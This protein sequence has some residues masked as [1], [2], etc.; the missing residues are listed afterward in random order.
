MLFT[1]FVMIIIF[2]G[3][4]Y[5]MVTFSAK[6]FTREDDENLKLIQREIDHQKEL[7]KIQNQKIEVLKANQDALEKK[8]D[9][10]FNPQKIE[11]LTTEEIQILERTQLQL[12]YYIGGESKN[13]LQMSRKFLTE[14]S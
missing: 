4:F 6:F 11:N 5:L 10:V 14:N 2:I 12:F 13:L 7:S 3:L 1:L 9:T 8:L